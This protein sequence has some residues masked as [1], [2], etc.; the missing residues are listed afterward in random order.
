MPLLC[1]QD[2]GGTGGEV[3]GGTSTQAAGERGESAG[4]RRQGQ[5]SGD[6][7][8]GAHQGMGVWYVCVLCGR[9]VLSDMCAATRPAVWRPGSWS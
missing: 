6:Q 4:V 3:A 8:H 7:G 2:A 1:I 5:P 9:C